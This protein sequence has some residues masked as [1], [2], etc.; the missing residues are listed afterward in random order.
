MQWIDTSVQ[1][2]LSAMDVTTGSAVADARP[3]DPATP[4][5]HGQPNKARISVGTDPGSPGP[6]PQLGLA[7]DQGLCQLRESQ[8]LALKLTEQLQQ[9]LVLIAAANGQGVTRSGAM[10]QGDDSME[11]SPTYEHHHHHHII[12]VDGC[13]PDGCMGWAHTMG[14]PSGRT[15]AVPTRSKDTT[16]PVDPTSV[17]PMPTRSECPKPRP[18]E[19]E[20]PATTTGPSPAVP[21]KEDTSQGPAELLSLSAELGSP[22]PAPG[23]STVDPSEPGS[24]CVQTE[25]YPWNLAAGTSVGP[26]VDSFLRGHMA[27]PQPQPTDGSQLLST[28]DS[29]ASSSAHV[30]QE[31]QVI[32]MLQQQYRSPD[33]TNHSHVINSQEHTPTSAVSATSSH[34]SRRSHKAAKPEPGVIPDTGDTRRA[35]CYFDGQ[36]TQADGPLHWGARPGASSQCR[37]LA[38]RDSRTS[39][40]EFEHY[41]D[42]SIPAPSG[43]DLSCT[44]DTCSSCLRA[45]PGDLSEGTGSELATAEVSGPP[46][47]R[48]VVSRKVEAFEKRRTKYY[49][50]P[51]CPPDANSSPASTGPV[52]LQSIFGETP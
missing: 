47:L 36:D 5:P 28:V 38:Y 46:R 51:S 7:T 37:P 18:G 27:G 19:S 22:I 15:A 2:H 43:E 31:E 41:S 42:S 17:S 16:Q 12:P 45:L 24:R 6:A 8:Q 34:H 23:P 33:T 29:P 21:N 40:S 49:A 13:N 26:Y 35:L 20:E 32:R 1:C 11:S 48:D 14:L 10:A 52:H 30:S 39:G 4:E 50:G 9:Q 3:P 44:S 25:A